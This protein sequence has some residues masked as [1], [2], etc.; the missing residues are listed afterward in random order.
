MKEHEFKQEGIKLKNIDLT[1]INVIEQ[2][3]K[4]KEE[5][6]EFMVAIESADLESAIDEFYDTI[7]SKLGLLEK[8][9]GITA[10]EVMEQYPKHLEKL[11]NRPR[12]K[13]K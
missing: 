4:V 1:G 2:L 11:K 8:I 12:S 13:D 7:Q 5:E 6:M 3:N 10:K 9:F